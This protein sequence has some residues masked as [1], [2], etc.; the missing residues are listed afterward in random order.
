MKRQP[1]TTKQR[2]VLDFIEECITERHMP[3]TRHEIR[4]H[5]DLASVN[6][7]DV[8]LRTLAARGYIELDR[9]CARGIR[10]TAKPKGF[11]LLTF[12][13]LESLV[14]TTKTGVK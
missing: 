13:K 6:S 4:E 10:L 1:I 3:P 12:E 7:A 8:Y 14:R 11:A 9:G 5:F 2:A